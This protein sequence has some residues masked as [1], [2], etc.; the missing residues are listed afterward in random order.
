MYLQA[1]VCDPDRH[2]SRIESSQR[3][4]RKYQWSDPC[5][6]VAGNQTIF[7]K[8]VHGFS[9]SSWNRRS[10]GPWCSMNYFAEEPLD[11]VCYFSSSSAIL[12]DFGSCD[13]AVANRFLMAY[14][15]YRN[16]QPNKENGRVKPSPSIGRYGKTEAWDL[17][18]T[19]IPGCI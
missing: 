9:K 8:R 13:Y 12:G 5:G 4:F 16:Q 10:K 7:T 18:T 11:F 17:V 19:G 15:H 3:A 2:E 14:A 1:D 6:G